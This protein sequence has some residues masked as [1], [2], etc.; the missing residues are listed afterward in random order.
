MS[1]VTNL[2]LSVRRRLPIYILNGIRI[3]AC[4]RSSSSTTT[5]AS[6]NPAK[7]PL[8]GIRVLDMTRV[9]AGVSKTILIQSCYAELCSRMDDSHTVRKSLGI[10]VPKSSR[11]SIHNEGTTQG[12]PNSISARDEEPSLRHF[13][14]MGS[15]LR[16]LQSLLRQ[17]WAR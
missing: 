5:A 4:R 11:L 3:P 8:V 13:Q 10:L 17:D 7:L 1:V 6:V 9:L 14:S 12:G 2:P 15:A 16:P